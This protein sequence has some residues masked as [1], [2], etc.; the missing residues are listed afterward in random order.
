MIYQAWWWYPIRLTQHL[1]LSP[2]ASSHVV[3]HP[4]PECYKNKRF[5]NPPFKSHSPQ[6]INQSNLQI[7]QMPVT[8]IQTL[9]EF[10]RIV[11]HKWPYRLHIMITLRLLDQWRSN[12]CNRF[13]GY[14][15]WSLSSYV[16][17]YGQDLRRPKFCRT[18]ILQ[19]WHRWAPRDCKGSWRQIRTSYPWLKKKWPNVNALLD[20]IFHRFQEW[21]QNR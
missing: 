5:L 19:G 14:L 20:P 18:Q 6:L 21:Q 1:L 16:A 9:E 4:A 12:S 11:S 7:K 2:L 17:S 3:A 13:L 10:K 8:A 15:V